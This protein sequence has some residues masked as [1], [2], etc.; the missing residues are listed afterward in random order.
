MSEESVEGLIDQIL[1]A[2]NARDVDRLMALL[3]PEIEFYSRLLQVD[4]RSYQG[5]EGMRRFLAE[6]DEAFEGAHWA[7]DEITGGA[8]DDLVVVLRQTMRGRTSQAPLDLPSFQAWKF[9]NGRPWHVA[10]YETREDAV[11]AAGLRE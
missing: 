3:D 11:E 4:G 6:V 10:V 8:G 5:E 7:L 2:L 1:Q 9:R